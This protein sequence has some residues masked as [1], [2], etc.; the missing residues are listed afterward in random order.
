MLKLLY[1]IYRYNKIEYLS[2][3]KIILAQVSIIFRQHA[4]KFT[5]MI[6]KDI[7][8]REDSFKMSYKHFKI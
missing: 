8:K 3:I 6:C 1:G 5:D 7:L 2:K 4:S